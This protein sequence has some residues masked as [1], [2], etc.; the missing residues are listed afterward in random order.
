MKININDDC[1]GADLCGL[2]IET[3]GF[4]LQQEEGEDK[5]VF[6][7]RNLTDLE[8]AAMREARLLCPEKAI[9]TLFDEMIQSNQH[10]TCK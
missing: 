6:E 1:C 5:P 2:C 10:R 7:Q 9:E 8:I 4:V 3:S